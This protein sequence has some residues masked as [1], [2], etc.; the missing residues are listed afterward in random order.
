MK[1]KMGENEIENVN[2]I[3]NEKLRDLANLI[4]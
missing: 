4:L 2:E 3:G 1:S